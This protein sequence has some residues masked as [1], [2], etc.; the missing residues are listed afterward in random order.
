MAFANQFPGYPLQNAAFPIPNPIF[1]PQQFPNAAPLLPPPPPPPQQVQAPPSPPAK[2]YSA[3]RPQVP[4]RKELVERTERAVAKAWRD[5]V[6]A[7]ESVSAWKV[8]QAALL[9]LGVDS[10]GSLGFPMQQVP[11]LYRLMATE[12]KIN[13]FIHCFVGVRRITSLY[14]LQVAICKNEGVERFEE[15][16]LGPLLRHSLVLHYFSLKPDTTSVYKITSE[17]IISYLCD[18]L[19]TSFKK[20]METEEFLDFIVKKRSVSS[21]EKLA[22]RIQNLG[23]HISCVREARKSEDV[24]LKSCSKSLKQRSENKRKKRPLFSIEKK[25]LDERFS[26]ISQRV[27]SF[28]SVHED[29]GV[30]HIRFLS[31]SSEDEDSD[32]CK[33]ED[34]KNEGKLSSYSDRSSRAT[35]SDRVSSC[36]Y[37][38]AVEEMTRLGLKAETDTDLSGGGSSNCDEIVTR[39]KKRK[40]KDALRSISNP[41][42]LL[43]RDKIDKDA[44]SGDN[45]SGEMDDASLNENDL[46]LAYSSMTM[47]ITTWKETCR[48][49]NVAQVLKG[50]LES[51]SI[52]A[53][54]RR[55][56]ISMF[57]TYPCL[58]LLNIAVTSIK[59]GMWDNIYDTLQAIDENERNKT[60]FDEGAKYEIIDVV[61]SEKNLAVTSTLNS[62]ATHSVTVEDVIS[63]V[64]SFLELDNEL[65]HKNKLSSDENY[66]IFK[67]LHDC[68]FWVAEQFSVGEF[69]SLGHGDFLA[70]L[71]RNCS[72]LPREVQELLTGEICE[73]TPFDIR[74]LQQQLVALVSQA[75]DNLWG[76]EPI[77]EQRIFMLLRQQFPLLNFKIVGGN[78]LK[79]FIEMVR[80]HRHCVTSRCVL[81]STSL[82]ASSV[83]DGMEALEVKTGGFDIDSKMERPLHAPCEDAIEVLLK[84]PIFSD[85]LSWSHWEQKFAPAHGPLVD[86]LLNE[87][88]SKELLCLVTNDGKVIRIDHSAT[89]DSFLEAAL[90]G[91]SFL[92]AVRLLSFFSL[93]GGEKHVPLSLLKSHACR[94]FEVITE[95][96]PD[97]I[98]ADVCRNSHMHGLRNK[99]LDHASSSVKGDLPEKRSIANEAVPLALKFFLDCLEHVPSEFC[100]FVADVLLTGLRSVVKDA[101]LAILKE[102]N[103]LQQWLLLRRIGFSLGIVEWMDDN[104]IFASTASTSSTANGTPCINTTGS[105]MITSLG[106]VEGSLDELSSSRADIAVSVANQANASTRARHTTGYVGDGDV[107]PSTE[108]NGDTDAA[109]VI[110]SIRRGEFGLD[111]T[112]S[113]TESD[114]LKKQHA[115]LGRA[116]HCLSQELYSQDSHF[117]LELVQNADDNLYLEN[118]EPTLTFILQDSGIIILNNER[119]FSAEN[120]RAL[121]DVGNSTKKGSRAGYIGQK[122]IGFKSV[123]RVTD[124]PEIH[125]NGFHVKFDI[126]EGQIGFVLPTLIPACN[127]DLFLRLASSDSDE[128]NGSCWNTCIVLPFRSKLSEGSA[129]KSILTM[130]SDLHP[131]LLLFLHRLQCIK[132]RDMLNDSMIIMRKE[133]LGDNIVKVSHGKDKMTWLVVSRKLQSDSIRRDVKITE[134]AMAFTLQEGD[135]GYY[136]P[137]LAQQPVFAFLPLRTYGLKFILQGDFVLPSSREEVDGDSPWNQWLLSECPELFASAMESFCALPCFRENPGKAISAYMSFVPLLGEVH[138]FFAILPRMIISRLRMSNCLL[139]EGDCCKWVPPCKVLRGWDEQAR[140]LL[141]D[142]LLQEHLG[143]GFLNKDIVLSDQLARALGIE[144]YGPKTLQ[145]FL[146]SLCNKENGLQSLGL[147]WLGRFLNV[148]YTMSFQSSGHVSDVFRMEK[149]LIKNLQKIPFIPLSDGTYSSL[150]RGPIWL[151]TDGLGSGSDGE[152]GLKA[153]PRMYMKLRIVSPALFSVTDDFSCLDM[154]YV[155]DVTKMLHKIGVQRLSAHEIVKVHILPSLSADRNSMDKNL[156]IEYVCFV[157]IHLQSGCPTCRVDKD[158]VISELRNKALI[159]TNYGFKRIVDVPIHFSEDY[160]NPINMHQLINVTDMRWHVVDS[161]YLKH[162]VTESFSC[163]KMKWRQFFQEMGI[164]DFLQVVQV[165]KS[166]AD[167]SSETSKRMLLDMDLI[168][169]GLVVK[170]WESKELV[171]M[172]SQ[173]SRT[174]N[175]ESCKYLL[176]VL[177][178]YW[179][180]LFCDK[181]KGYCYPTSDGDSRPFKSSFMNSICDLQWVVSS[182]DDHLHCPKD[183]FYDCEAVRLIL[184]ASVPY[185]VPKVRSEKLLSDIGFKTEVKLDDVLAMLQVWRRSSNLFKASVAQMA[186]LYSFIWNELASSQIRMS[187]EIRTSQFIFVPSASGFRREELVSGIFCSPKEVYW[188]DSTGSVKQVNQVYSQ[189]RLVGATDGPPCKT[190]DNIYPGLYD[191]FV[192][193][194]NVL[195]GPSFRVYLKMLAELSASALPSQV[196]NIVFQIFLKWNDDLVSGSITVEDV[197]YFKECLTKP[198]YTVLPTVLDK[199]VSLHPSCGIVCWS[200]D[201]NLRKELKHVEGVDF[202]YFGEPSNNQEMLPANVTKLLRTLGIPALSEVVTREA[203]YYG[204]ADST[205]KAQLIDWALPYAQ[206]YIYSVHPQQYLQLKQSGFDSLK[207]LQV[208]VVEN[209]FYR[210]VIKSCGSSSKKRY[211]CNCL[212]EGNVLYVA[213]QSDSHALFLEL[214]RLWFDGHPE[215]HIANFLHMITTMAESGSTEEQTETFILNS[216]KVT[217]IPDEETVWSLASLS[218]RDLEKSL[219]ISTTSGGTSEQ[220]VFK[221]RRKSGTIPNWPPVDWKTAPDFRYACENGF[222]TRAV[223]SISHEKLRLIQKLRSQ[224]ENVVPTEMDANWKIGGNAAAMSG[225]LA[226]IQNSEEHF[227]QSYG[228]VMDTELSSVDASAM[229]IVPAKCSSDVPVKSLP[230]FSSR[231]RLNTGNPD[232]AQAMLTG[233]LGENVAFRYFT[234]KAGKATVNW[235]NELSETGLPY[236]ILIGENEADREYIEVKA[237]TSKR[238]DWFNITTREWQFAVE[239]GESYSIA[240]VV[241]G[242]NS[243]ARV[244]I[245]KNPIKLCQQ[246]KLQLVVMMPRQETDLSGMS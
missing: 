238:K 123:F 51:Y 31:S 83:N 242:D 25:Q 221:S 5:L 116:L 26:S 3:A 220:T 8:S 79:D 235:V 58:G 170:D 48:E 74:M 17:E 109:C 125:S 149:D 84:A 121:C 107:H 198:E 173:F 22:V 16:E 192:R 46:S 72:E 232:G 12:G 1:P 59:C 203:I 28:S 113:I 98:D 237:T 97:S 190:L 147:S 86:F 111:P 217:K 9:A 144:A 105:E 103:K 229:T 6:A 62:E 131:S 168:T 41:N 219:V 169:P 93:V 172:L 118:V 14:D 163:G 73:K 120:I 158:S 182:M 77:T 61:P 191:F 189:G 94:A 40:S 29:F 2:P 81:Y 54:Q 85:L 39:K 155:D 160:G 90:R 50:M 15:L 195:E 24:T 44:L 145:Q 87:V 82:V 241:L 159:L 227:A 106:S 38:S 204:S 13:A 68:E 209:L 115:R 154:D 36:P 133:V 210:N 215:L 104:I 141:T 70:F 246:G 162:P 10:W 65:H 201:E 180:H 140:T 184:G 137:S 27:K 181:V 185:A 234:G 19:D 236:D 91:S 187:E 21:K 122:G 55:R 165:Q 157:M 92:T 78:F 193:E 244:S 214:S 150:D 43:R 245:F 33:D 240:H 156:M 56:I 177:D 207:Q 127:V 117:L 18:F 49:Q 53:R 166:I 188:H 148:L 208:V 231:E 224:L 153:F 222:R 151:H 179:E 67:K 66:N 101:P 143:L 23:M 124:A 218:S 32:D 212:L 164:T 205:L 239:Q 119:G 95:N 152:H 233:R 197:S 230:N 45:R 76:D 186:R 99:F 71:G 226:N 213:Q 88:N 139:L 175:K 11:A 194:C 80:E 135:C 228:T 47:F 57:S 108:L 96:F 225:L 161:S 243:T 112:L 202:L 142:G 167:I 7:G 37:P 75:A 211:D 102:C 52:T 35:K 132:F 196:A 171:Q 178:T 200:D 130:F 34:K 4:S 114:M 20:D 110:E 89:V 128:M 199:W 146:S 206:R 60:G 134:I 136:I 129:M 30:N 174:G 216:Q 183:L 176:E 64:T 223:D 42:K 100:T 63:K 138:G 69:K 126:T